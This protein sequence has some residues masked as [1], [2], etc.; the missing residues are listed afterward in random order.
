MKKVIVGLIAGWLMMLP[1]SGIAYEID[2][3]PD[4]KMSI[5][6][7]YSHVHLGGDFTTGSGAFSFPDSQKLNEN[8]F[9]ADL[10]LP[11][12]SI[13]T[14]T[15]GG[16]YITSSSDFATTKFTG[17]NQTSD[18]TGYSIGFGFRAYLP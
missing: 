16:G 13:L 15:V 11:L 14:F 5:G 8:F 3:N 9:N 18:V 7:G 1:K 6:L 10:R 4:R 2:G 17:I 12:N